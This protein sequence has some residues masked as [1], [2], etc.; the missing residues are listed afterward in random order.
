MVIGITGGI[1]AGKS[2]VLEYLRR[3]YDAAIIDTDAIGRNAIEP[4]GGV[5]AETRS[6]L[7]DA[8]FLPDGRPDRPKIASAVFQDAAL[9]SQ[10]NGIVHP[11]VVQTVRRKIEDRGESA[12]CV[13]E[14]ALLLES[15]LRTLCDSI[16]YIYA[17]EKVRRKRLKESRGYSAERIR[18]TM[19]AQKP[20]ADFRRAAD[21]VID[22][23]GDFCE[24]A[25]A[26]DAQL[27]SMKKGSE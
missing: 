27:L 25:S 18:V 15:G 12:L 16:W 13:I 22:N 21:A 26:V 6:L 11:Y 10:L 2:R 5:Y 8:C 24:T 17:D 4:G 14:S 20:D 7:G 19:A 23:S 1:G 3:K 9:L